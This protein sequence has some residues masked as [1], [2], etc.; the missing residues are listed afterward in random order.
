MFVLRTNM[1][2]SLVPPQAGEAARKRLP[3]G[4]SSEHTAA[5]HFAPAVPA[6]AHADS[7]ISH[8]A[9]RGNQLWGNS[10]GNLGSRPDSLGQ[11]RL[12]PPQPIHQGATAV[13]PIAHHAGELRGLHLARLLVNAAVGARD[14]TDLDE[15]AAALVRQRAVGE[16]DDLQLRP[17][18]L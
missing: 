15:G 8:S 7:Q 3:P 5:D 4:A 18:D 1:S 12:Q 6:R 14:A 2:F 17:F 16:R 9:R 10:G 11:E 13:A